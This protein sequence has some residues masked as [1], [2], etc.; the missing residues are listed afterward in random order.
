MKTN[1]LF[2]LIIFVTGLFLS[3][4]LHGETPLLA[5][6]GISVTPHMLVASMHYA[7]A[8]EPAIGALVQ[9][10]LRNDTSPRHEPLVLDKGTAILFENNSPAELLQK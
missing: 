4:V 9:L 3:P 6:R 10:F 2:Y 5:L 8:P 1:I 7:R